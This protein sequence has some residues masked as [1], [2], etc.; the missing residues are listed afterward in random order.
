MPLQLLFF[1]HAFKLMQQMYMQQMYMQQMYVQ[2][3]YTIFSKITNSRNFSSEREIKMVFQKSLVTFIT[4]GVPNSVMALALLLL[5][6]DS[7]LS[8][9]IMC[10]VHWAAD[11]W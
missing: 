9:C 2:E 5:V 7:R 6:T 4:S 11:A 10:D 1:M 3:M 8:V